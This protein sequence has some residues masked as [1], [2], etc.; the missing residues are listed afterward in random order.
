MI[1]KMM[2]LTFRPIEHAQNRR[3]RTHLPPSPRKR[4]NIA[5]EEGGGGCIINKMF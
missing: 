4:K 3:E 1:I 2:R 5:N